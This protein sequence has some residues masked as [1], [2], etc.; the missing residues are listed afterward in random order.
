MQCSM[1]PKNIVDDEP[2]WRV[3]CHP[4]G[5]DV[6]APRII[7][8]RWQ[9]RR[10]R[11][12]EFNAE[13]A[14]DCHIVKIVLRT[15]NIRFSVSSRTVHD[16]V[17]TPGTVHV[18]EPTQPVHCLFRGPYD[19]LHLH[20]P[21]KMIAECARDMPGH[22]TPVL[23][24]KAVPSKDMMIDS[25]ARALL[26][27]NWVGGS[28]GQLYADCLG[29]AIVTRLLTSADCV[30]RSDR[31]K[32][33]KLVQWRL[34]RAIDYIEARLDEPISLADIA[35][36]VGLTRMHFAAQF[37]AATGFRPHEYLLRRRIER[38]QDMLAGSSMPL[39]EVAQSVGFQTQS[40][41][42]TVFKRYTGRPPRAWRES[43]GMQTAPTSL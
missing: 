8:T 7:A 29:V 14:P 11:T 40:H 31:P 5:T 28:L 32:G 12:L 10:E 27:S 25:L 4:S 33:G 41:F 21:N 6:A 39:V 16:G 2:G 23:C 19:V 1:Y 15:M 36:S 42:T 9:A 38:A 13:T 43:G 26:E 35:S 3:L 34:K 24:S 20:V 30:A 17:I 18:T 22:Q 37:R